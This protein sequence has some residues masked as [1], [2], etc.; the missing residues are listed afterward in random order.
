MYKKIG[1]RLIDLVISIIGLPFFGIIFI[2]FAPIIKLTDNGPVFYNA[3][4]LGWKGKVY[5][6]YKFRSMRVNA[7][8]IRNADGSTYN[9]DD[10][11]RVTKIGRIMR[12]TSVDETP[13]ILNVLKGDMSIIGPRPF[14][15]TH[16][17]GYDK[18][19]EKRKKRL[20]VRP[21]IT[22][23]SQAYYRNSIGQ[24]EKIDN[25]CYYVD[26]V[27]L[28]LDVKIF[29]Q[30]IRSVIKRENIYVDSAERKKSAST[31]KR[32]AG[33]SIRRILRTR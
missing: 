9:G 25:D 24:Q 1:K 31:Q 26:H 29:F 28:G 20:E 21:G 5:K 32:A 13:Q 30:T 19:D 14:V 8:D 23:Y 15:T 22:G 12:K 2:I 33:R 27:S 4:R 10:D 17:E 16:Y 7:P 6:M 11:P 18:L 3:E